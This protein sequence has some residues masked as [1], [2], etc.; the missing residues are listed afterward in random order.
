MK[1]GFLQVSTP[2]F[3]D[4]WSR[5][6]NQV[7]VMESNLAEVKLGARP[8]IIEWGYRDNATDQK[9]ILAMSC[10][11]NSDDEYWVDP[12]ILSSFLT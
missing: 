4:V 12:S 6:K 2:Q 9:I 11:S 1:P 3:C 8:L 10:S 7:D 5:I